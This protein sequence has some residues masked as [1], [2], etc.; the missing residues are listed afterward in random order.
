MRILGIDP[1]EHTSGVVL[2]D[3]APYVRVI[4]GGRVIWA[5]KAVPNERLLAWLRC[6]TMQP[7][8]NLGWTDVVLETLVPYG[9]SFGWSTL[10]TAELIGQI[11]EAAAHHPPTVEVHELTRLEVLQ[12]LFGSK[13][14]NADSAVLQ[15]C[16]A[17][18]GPKG[19]KAS[20]GPTYGVSGHAWQALGAVWAH[21]KQ[22]VKRCAEN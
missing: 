15:L 13:P 4:W 10:R 17:E 1:G 12:T 8:H 18:I 5:D 9:L 14:A 11:R 19:T 3:P 7:D 6:G 2:L 21:V 16:Q 22:E 20:P